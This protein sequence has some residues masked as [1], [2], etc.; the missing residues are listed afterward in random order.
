MRMIRYFVI[1]KTTGKRLYTHCY[2]SECENFMNALENK[3]N[4]TIGYKWMSI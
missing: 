2:R 4:Y 1:N 3:E